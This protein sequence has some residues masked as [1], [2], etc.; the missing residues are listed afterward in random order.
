MDMVKQEILRTWLEIEFTRTAARAGYIPEREVDV[1][2]NLLLKT[3]RFL[4]KETAREGII[5]KNIVICVIALMWEHVDHDKYNLRVIVLRFLARIGYPT[6]AIVTDKGFDSKCGKFSSIDSII[7]E[8]VTSAQIS[9]N[10]ISFNKSSYLLTDFQMKIWKSLESEKHICISAPTSAGKSFVILLSL[11]KKIISNNLDIVYIVPTISLVNQVTEDF[12]KM[13][14]KYNISNCNITSVY[15]VHSI[16]EKNIYV[17]T[18]EKAIAAFSDNNSAF[19]RATVVIADEIQNIERILDETDE[20]AKILLDVLSEFRE[21]KN[22]TQTIISGPRIEKIGLVGQRIWGEVVSEH[23]T[24]ESPVFNITYSIRKI[25]SRYFL[26]QYSNIFNNPIVHEITN[27]QLIGGYGKKIYTDD[28]LNSLNMLV[29]NLGLDKQNIVFAPTAQTARRVALALGGGGSVETELINYYKETIHPNYS[30]CTTISHGVAYHHGKLPLHVRRTLESAISDGKICTVVC[31]TT[32]MQGV[33]LPAQNVIIRNPHLYIRKRSNSAELT[34]YEMANLRG[35]TGRLMKEFVGRA[36][37]MDESEFIESEG[38]EQQSLFEETE[39]ELPSGYEEK[40]EEYRGS[41]EAA[42][43]TDQPVGNEM[44]AYG[45]LV[46]YIRQTVLKYGKEAT[47]RMKN[48]GIKLTQKQVAAI[49]FKLE[50]L[51]VPREVCFKNRYWDPFVLD[52][53]YRNYNGNPP[54]SVM[55]KGAKASITEMM[56]FLRDNSITAP[57]YEKYI[58]SQYRNGRN[59]SLLIK[60]SFQ[61]ATNVPLKEILSEPYYDGEEGADRIEDTIELLQNVVSYNL[62]LLLKPLFDMRKSENSVLS[63]LQSGAMN[64]HIIEMIDLG[65]PRETALF[66]YKELEDSFNKTGA[67]GQNVKSIIKNN[68]SRFPYWVKVQLRFLI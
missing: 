51:S 20:R 42:I 38:Y 8:I 21:K 47:S 65:I 55:E 25:G 11:I 6:S 28:Y 15:N 33:N 57:I 2:Y 50:N 1:T 18:Q 17:L 63:S 66:V 58:P 29:T 24:S 45:H 36:F 4:D 39:K 19:D 16:E 34:N 26:K 14:N 53:I 27:R 40:F 48:V 13:V 12:R 22:V 10:E 67:T 54:S 41:I 52:Y 5:D 9:R 32:L 60:R 68:M 61:W 59:R 35:R 46:T 62:P 44:F 49:I 31:T 56:R 7:D 37:V 23:E 3:I 30:L 64:A 43:D